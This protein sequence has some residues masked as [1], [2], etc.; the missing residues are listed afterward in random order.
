MTL[1]GIIQDTS[2]SYQQIQKDYLTYLENK[3]DW[4]KWKDLFEGSEGKIIIEFLS[5]KTAYEVL[6][7]F[8]YWQENQLQYLT[9]QE[10]AVAVSQNYSYSAGRGINK[11]SYVESRT[12][13]YRI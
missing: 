3:D 12:D 5:S 6:K 7:I 8:N 11:N 9:K 4:A 13:C 2:L 10:S 1:N